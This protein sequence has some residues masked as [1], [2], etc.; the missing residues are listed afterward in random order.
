MAEPGFSRIKKVP[1]VK[2]I[3]DGPRINGWVCD[4]CN[5]V[6]YAVEIHEGVTPFFLACRAEGVDPREAKCKGRGKSLMYPSDPP[7]AEVLAAVRW[8]WFTPTGAAFRKLDAG[9]RE[10][11]LKGGL[12]L[13]K[14]TDDGRVALANQE[15]REASDE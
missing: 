14:L 1:V 11:I 12:E 8:E 2:P 4:R 3:K 7:P 13:R 15:D 6:T 9:M 5:R 10:H